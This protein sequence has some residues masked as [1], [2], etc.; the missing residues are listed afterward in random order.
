MLLRSRILL[1]VT[2][3]PVDDGGV[4][5]RD[6]RIVAAGMWSEVSALGNG[7]EVVDLGEVVLL[8]GLVNAHAHLEYTGM[9]GLLTGVNGFT[10][11]IRSINAAK[12]NFG[13]DASTEQWLA[14]AIS[15][16][17][18]GTTMVADIQTVPAAKAAKP[19]LTP[20]SIIP[21][22]EMTG[23]ISRRTPEDLLAEAESFLGKGPLGGGYSPHSPYST[24]PALLELTASRMDETD[25]VTT[26]HVAESAEEFD[27]FVNRRGPMFDFIASLGRPMDDCDGRTPLQHV[28]SSGL[29]KRNALLVHANYLT[30]GDVELLA[31]SL[32]SVVH[33]PGSHAFFDHQ[34]FRYDDLLRREVNI[35][36]G[37]DSM[38]T[39][40]V[41]GEQPNG[42]SMLAEMQRFAHH[43]PDVAPREI[44]AMATINGA[45][46][47][48][49]GQEAGSLDAGVRADMIGIPF[50]GSIR[51]AEAAIF[52]EGAKL[53]VGYIGGRRSK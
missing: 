4:W 33:C 18:T 32:A 27:M 14:G 48:G 34:P 15:L 35:C 39:M 13:A 51:D 42:L 16:V 29:L 23:V 21:F 30:D 41:D 20:L 17:E 24:L 50:Q 43:H 11:W 22:I 52:A 3:P 47:L 25:R 46:A 53:E 36:L 37:T 6:G 9:A 7:D 12:Q 40:N 38:A 26:V 8:P 45:I 44:L 19:K 28:A 1:P 10:E 31:N 49:I 2:S 5:V